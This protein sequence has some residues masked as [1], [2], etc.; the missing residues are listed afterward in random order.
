MTLILSY[1][2]IEKAEATKTAHK[3]GKYTL[4]GGG[5]ENYEDRAES[6]KE[7]TQLVNL[8]FGDK[9]KLSLADFKAVT[10][11][12]TSEMF[13]C[14]FS[15]LKTTFPSYAQFSRYALALGQHGTPP[16]GAVDSFTS[17]TSGS[18]TGSTTS[19]AGSIGSPSVGLKLAQPRVLSRFAP[20]SQLVKCA[21]PK[22]G[23]EV[24][25]VD[26]SKKAEI[27]TEANDE[28]SKVSLRVA[29]SAA[30]KPYRSQLAPKPKS[31]SR[32][33]PSGAEP[34]AVPESPITEAVRLPNAKVN[35]Q[36]MLASPSKILG[37]ERDSL[38]FCE[39][40]KEIHDL[41]K[42]QCDDCIFNGSKYKLEGLL[43]KKGKTGLKQLWIVLDRREIYSQLD[44]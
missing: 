20:L 1:V 34:S 35:S 12:V 14:L 25:R 30:Q 11:S 41:N 43:T 31:K 24:L 10:E 28:D 29:P 36:D 33:A 32:F 9:S 21:T 7:L 27:E 3:E 16:S 13:L 8:A 39:C 19:T 15:L 18:V 40:G 23:S 22:L 42:L 38:L 26:K 37:V 4:L 17:A 44:L 2:P 5:G 6:Q